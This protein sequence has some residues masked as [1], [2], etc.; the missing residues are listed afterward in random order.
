MDCQNW[1]QCH[2][3]RSMSTPYPHFCPPIDDPA[4]FSFK[5]LVIGDTCVGKT[6]FINM[7]CEHVFKENGTGTIGMDLK[8]NIINVDGKKIRLLVWDTAGQERFRTLTTAY[9][10]GAMGI[11][12]L[13]DV[14]RETSFDH[15]TSWLDDIAR[16]VSPDICKVLVGNKSDF[17]RA[18]RV[19]SKRAITLSEAFNF[20]YIEASAKTGENVENVFETLTRQ[21]LDRYNKKMNT[22]RPLIARPTTTEKIEL[23]AKKKS[24]FSVCSC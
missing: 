7:F 2:R 11:I 20:P 10:R 17:T 22:N 19:P 15:V 21:M 1:Q 14:T 12:I 18:R 13:Y 24:T 5:I 8:K 23:L 6:S 3:P 16:N 4:D 9:Y